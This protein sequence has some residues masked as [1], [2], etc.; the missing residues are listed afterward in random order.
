MHSE[1]SSTRLQ[2]FIRFAN[3]CNFYAFF[4]IP[5]LLYTPGPQTVDS[6][7]PHF[8]GTRAGSHC[9]CT[10]EQCRLAPPWSRLQTMPPDDHAGTSSWLKLP[11]GMLVLTLYLASAFSQQPQCCFATFLHK[12]C[13]NF[14]ILQLGEMKLPLYLSIVLWRLVGKLY[15]FCNLALDVVEW[16]GSGCITR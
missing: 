4:K 13:V 14:S 8:W 15:I 1:S 10:L 12:L 9:T 6:C 5:E 16:P 3:Y 2:L 11:A 7:L